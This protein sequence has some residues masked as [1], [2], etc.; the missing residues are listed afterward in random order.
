MK[1]YINGST[2]EIVFQ[3]VQ[4]TKEIGYLNPREEAVCLG[5]IS[6][7]AVIVYNIDKTTNKKVGFVKWLGGIK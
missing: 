4:C 6:G 5:E 3:D 1:K 2:K 7:K